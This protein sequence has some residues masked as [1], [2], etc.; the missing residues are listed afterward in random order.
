MAATDIAVNVASS[1]GWFLVR[2]IGAIL[3][4]YIMSF[5]VEKAGFAARVLAAWLA[6]ICCALYGVVASTVLRLSGNVGI[7]QWA[8][9]RSFKYTMAAA[10]GV[11]FEI[12]DPQN[13]LNT[14]RPAVFVGN[15]Q[16]AL[17][18]LVLGCV[19]PKYCSV[20]AKTSL[21]YYPFL[22]W[23]MQLS[24][25][26][27]IDRGNSKDA[28]QAMSGAADAIRTR[29]QSVYMFPEGTRSHTLEPAM[30]P[31]KKGAFHLAVQAGVPIVP[32]VVA[33]YSHVYCMK[34]FLFRSG[35][36]P[37]KGKSPATPRP[38][39]ARTRR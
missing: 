27:F 8:A 9:G 34:K 28:R 18:V 2:Y 31:F 15:H 32:I 25:S 29:R 16:S 10:T 7:S 39:V 5:V 24:G 38:R 35:K 11:T 19:F 26:V 6:L 37:V 4:L 20:T 1:V 13:H 14:T 17:D 30:L 3:V 22:G 23:F 36:I 33:N 21:K 12:E